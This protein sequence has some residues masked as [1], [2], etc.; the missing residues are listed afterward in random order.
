MAYSLGSVQSLSLCSSSR[1]RR[2]PREVAGAAEILIRTRYRNSI[3]ARVAPSFG[4]R[5]ASQEAPERVAC[6]FEHAGTRR[7]PKILTN[8]APFGSKVP[9]RPGGKVIGSGRQKARN[10]RPGRLASS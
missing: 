3:S 6:A 10:T 7:L 9:T 4:R 8:G 5:R 2:F 1:R